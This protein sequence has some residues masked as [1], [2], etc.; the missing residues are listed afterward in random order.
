MDAFKSP[1][2]EEGFSVVRGLL[3]A[4]DCRRL[5]ASFQASP[6]DQPVDWRKGHVVSDPRFFALGTFRG[7]VDRVASL[8][9]K[10][11]VLF[12]GVLL[13]R[14]PGAVHPWHTDMETAMPEGGTVSVWIGLENLCR[15]TSLHVIAGSHRLG[16]S[17]Q[18]V[19]DEQAI[20][21]ERMDEAGVE[22]WS[23][24]LD[25]RCRLEKPDM[26]DGDA[27]FFDGRLWHGTNNTTARE[28]VALLLHYAR[29]DVPVR[30]GD[31]TKLGWPMRYIEDPKPP[32]LLVRGGSD[33][34]VNRIVPAPSFSREGRPRI[35]SR[36]SPVSL[37]FRGIPEHGKGWQVAFLH[38]GS[39]AY[40]DEFSCH[41]S[42]LM[43]GIRTHP[44]HRHDH[45]ELVLM[46]DGT[47][48]ILLGR[49]GW[50]SRR[51]EVG[52]YVF[53]PRGCFHTMKNRTDRPVSYMVFKWRRAA[54]PSVCG[55]DALFGW[56]GD[57]NG[58]INIPNGRGFQACG[59]MDQP[60]DH[61][62]KLHL[63]RSRL[64]PGGGY[65]PHADAYDVA[66][67]VLQGNVESLGV[68]AKPYDVF[69]FAAGEPHGIH[70]P[71]DVPAEY[72][73]IEFHG[74]TVM[75]VA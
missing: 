73:V 58:W 22:A 49:F 13:R 42:C 39:T 47:L 52:Q 66:L 72:L 1:F 35:A 41:A 36:L 20:P 12:G 38:S 25:V 69:H 34:S 43:P 19:A 63:H 27:V 17:V 15:E 11:V 74:D 14:P 6:P 29:A 75:P 50:S 44:P 65:E 16:V 62:R 45:E 56:Y 4:G 53:L 31:V 24:T 2:A 32:C 54:S 30:E 55:S 51:L 7:I 67:I 57:H 8:L 23:R 48:D 70:N 40:L 9:G 21:R 64:Q 3:S 68:L 33:A 59:I 10:D 18:Q 5:V 37:P 61:L 26:A 71:G 60:V 46:L 28:R